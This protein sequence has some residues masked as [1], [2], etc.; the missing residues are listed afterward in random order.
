MRT[1]I[2]N[3]KEEKKA[4]AK[5]TL[6]PNM[7]QSG[8]SCTC[9]NVCASACVFVCA[10]A[11]IYVSSLARTHTHALHSTWDRFRCLLKLN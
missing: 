10:C 8:Y 7:T 11:C 9:V 1:N 3:M 2:Q 4:K 5:A 6:L